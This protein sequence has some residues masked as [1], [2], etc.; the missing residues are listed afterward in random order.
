MSYARLRTG[1]ELRVVD[2]SSWGVL[3]ETRERLLPG[4]HL[5][6]HVVAS[7]GRVL[8]RTRVIRAYVCGLQADAIDYR[9]ALAFEQTVDILSMGYAMPAPVLEQTEALGTSYPSRGQTG[10]IEFTEP[11]SA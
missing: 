4:R 10:D 7:N 2:A 1:G 9:A 5:D 8:V 11:L 3:A 6:V